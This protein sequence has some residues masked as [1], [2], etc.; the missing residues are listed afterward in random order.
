MQAER[1]Q[2][3]LKLYSSNKIKKIL[4][5]KKQRT[6]M[7]GTVPPKHKIKGSR[8]ISPKL[9]HCQCA[10]SFFFVRREWPL[11]LKF[12]FSFLR[13]PLACWVFYCQ[14]PMNKL[15]CKNERDSLQY[16]PSTHYDEHQIWNENLK[17]LPLNQRTSIVIFSMLAMSVTWVEGKWLSTLVNLFFA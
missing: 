11:H 8:K 14:A 17:C 12:F 2:C 5:N 13:E 7:S 6:K 9:W 16:S 3:T 1:I 15:G 10:P 4:A